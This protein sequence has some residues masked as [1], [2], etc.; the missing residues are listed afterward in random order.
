MNK[1]KI[2]TICKE[3]L[4]Q[5]G[6]DSRGCYATDC[7]DACCRY[8]CDVDKASYDLLKENKK[9]IK[10]TIGG[11]FSKLFSGKQANDEEYPGGSF[12]RSKKAKETGYCIF[13]KVKST[14][15]NLYELVSNNKLPIQA[16]PLI[17]RLYPL[18]WGDG[19]LTLDHLEKNTCDI[20]RQD[21]DSKRTIM[22]TQK[23]ALDEYFE[24]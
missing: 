10:N 6:F 2:N 12:I 1:I 9:L 19:E 17:C 4:S 16:I 22:E 3:C 23:D 7:N 11:S 14:G 5:K 24:Y 8:G 15:C 20:F 18:E 21:N 13:H